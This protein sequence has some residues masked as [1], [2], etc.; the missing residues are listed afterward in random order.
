M[1]H[2]LIRQESV[3]ADVNSYTVADPPQIAAHEG[4]LS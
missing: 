3:P 2:Y 4:S 1:E